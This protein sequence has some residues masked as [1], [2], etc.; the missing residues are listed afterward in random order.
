[1]LLVVPTHATSREIPARG[2]RFAAAF[3]EDTP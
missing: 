3:V 2:T 1:V